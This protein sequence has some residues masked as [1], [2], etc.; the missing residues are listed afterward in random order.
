MARSPGIGRNTE[1]EIAQ[2]DWD[3]AIAASIIAQEARDAVTERRKLMRKGIEG[4]S[5][6]LEDLDWV[7]KNRET[8]VDTLIKEMKRKLGGLMSWFP[9]LKSQFDL[10]NGAPPPPERQA[11]FL[12]AGKLA[13][14]QGKP[15]SPPQN[16]GD[17][18]REQWLT[19]WHGGHNARDVS[20][21]D[22]HVKALAAVI[23]VAAIKPLDDATDEPKPSAGTANPKPGGG[24]KKLSGEQRRKALNAA[25]G[26]PIQPQSPPPP[27]PPPPPGPNQSPPPPNREPMIP[28]AALEPTKGTSIAEAE[29]QF[30]KDNPGVL[31]PGDAGFVPPKPR[32]GADAPKA[33]SAV[34]AERLAD[35]G[36]TK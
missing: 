19:G 35:A 31:M 16:L 5:I 22:P 8:P 2:A 30:R 10:F 33:Q 7:V 3:V 15:A 1:A 29:A 28:A 4:K 9:H 20:L 34:A 36:I 17:V 26:Q 12:L 6:V 27:P 21:K 24:G 11:A 23:K 18:E 13:G 32:P 14:M 25:G